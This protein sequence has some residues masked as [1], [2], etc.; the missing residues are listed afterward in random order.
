MKKVIIILIVVIIVV[1]GYLTFF[2]KTTEILE[3]ENQP[4]PSDVKALSITS[5]SK[6]VV[7]DSY[8]VDF[9]FPV[10]GEEKIDTEINR[11][12]DQLVSS[13]EKDANSFSPNI[14]GED[15]KYTLIGNFESKL[16]D[17][18]D[19]FIFSMSIDFGGAHPNHF[20]R[21][22]TFNKNRDIVNLEKLLN[23]E[24]QGV[25]TLEKISE[26]S[27]EIISEKLGENNNEEMLSAGT[28]PELNSFRNFYIDKDVIVF[29][30]EPYAVAPYAY[31][32]QEARINF[33]ELK[34]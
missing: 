14:A 2:N 25:S 31:S 6:Q 12:I 16:G 21:T 3:V 10:T 33:S 8:E 26:L 9:K 28:K 23:E 34:I 24:F 7:N 32:N 11:N 13:F 20:Y 18:Y 19:T 1:L 27:R 5:S 30:F 4:A 15:R 17:K 22:I 29:L